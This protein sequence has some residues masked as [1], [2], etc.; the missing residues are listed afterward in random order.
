MAAVYRER[1]DDERLQAVTD[2]VRGW[3]FGGDG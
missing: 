2:Y 3:W 1:V